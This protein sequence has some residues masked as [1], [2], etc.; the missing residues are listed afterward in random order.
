[1]PLCRSLD[2]IPPQPCEY[3]QLSIT[4]NTCMNHGHNFGNIGVTIPRR[5][6]PRFWSG[7]EMCRRQHDSIDRF[8][9]DSRNS[10][11]DESPSEIIERARGGGCTNP[12][13]QYLCLCSHLQLTVR[14]PKPQLTYY[15]MPTLEENTSTP[16]TVWERR[17]ETRANFSGCRAPR[18]VY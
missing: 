4:W 14:C 17:S 2:M 18:C 11:R 5:L 1:M 8:G 9:I 13:A 16:G 3:V 7:K 15:C 12:R 6:W 10:P